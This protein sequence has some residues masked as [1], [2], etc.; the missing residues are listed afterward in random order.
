MMAE[1]HNASNSDQGEQYRGSSQDSIP[2]EFLQY[3]KGLFDRWAADFD[4][5]D[6]KAVGIMAV[7]G[8]LV[9]FQ[10]LNLDNLV[11]VFGALAKSDAPPLLR[12]TLLLLCVHGSALLTTLILALLAFQIKSFEYP[13]DVSELITKFR[14]QRDKAK[15]DGS[16]FAGYAQDCL[17][18][19]IVQE[20]EISSTDICRV[21]SI[22]ARLLKW[23]VFL[24]ILSIITLGGFIIVLAVTKATSS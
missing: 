17:R 4:H 12:I 18:S 7:V 16:D 19:H 3:S 13:C 14:E 20:Y 1:L 2:E 5:L 8:L 24:L 11:Y 21:N 9:G 22:K 6:N 15:L 23:S 10:A